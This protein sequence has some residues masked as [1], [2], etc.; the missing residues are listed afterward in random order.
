MSRPDSTSGRQEPAGPQ[1]TA[2][3]EFGAQFQ[4]SYR[5]LWLIAAGVIGDPSLADDVVQEA[6]VIALGKLD[7]F[8]PGTAFT[9]WMGQIVR[10][11]ALN[12]G[13]AEMRRRPAGLGSGAFEPAAPPGR[14]D[15]AGRIDLSARGEMPANQDYFD[16]R[17]MRALGSVNEM[18]RA[19]L[20]LRTLEGL[21]YAEIA[22]LLEIPEG[23]AMSHVHR[24]RLYLRERLADLWSGAAQGPTASA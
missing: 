10:Y 8:R 17:I 4:A 21:S 16:D 6:A 5:V 14:A 3:E 24:T 23:T 19:C 11:V 13:R 9:A 15:E 1:R 22:R 12:K 7:Q 20:L 18:A 2:A